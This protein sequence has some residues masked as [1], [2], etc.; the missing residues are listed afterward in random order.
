MDNDGLNG[1]NSH[2]VGDQR[3]GSPCKVVSSYGAQR[4]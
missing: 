3:D 1:H 2:I 4:M